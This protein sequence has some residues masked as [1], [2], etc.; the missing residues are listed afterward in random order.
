VLAAIQALPEEVTTNRAAA[1][2]LQE[3]SAAHATVGALFAEASTAATRA[4]LTEE[5]RRGDVLLNSQ[6]LE[7]YFS[8]K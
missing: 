5:T 1:F 2:A 6:I 7:H 8:T 4:S 3:A